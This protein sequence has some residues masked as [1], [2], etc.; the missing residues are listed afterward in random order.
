MTM[1]DKFVRER[2]L[3]ERL[4]QRLQID[5]DAY[6]NPNA[7]GAETGAD[8]LVFH[9]EDRI[10]LQVSVLDTGAIPGEAI[11]AEKKLANKAQKTHG[12]AYSICGQNQPLCA[13]AATIK[14]KAAVDVA[15]FDQVWLLVSCSI[16]ENGAVGSTFLMTDLITADALNDATSALL[17]SSKYARAFLH[18]IFNWEDVLYEWTRDRQWEKHVNP[19]S[20]SGGV[21]LLG[22]SEGDA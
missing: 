2:N 12:G 11:K 16:P 8:V 19:Q 13:I 20:R 4:V 18:P 5:V 17:S 9:R 21:D 1:T 3:V 14:K 22:Y 6:D 10:G 15:G 7:G